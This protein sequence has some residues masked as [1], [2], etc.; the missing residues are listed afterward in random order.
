MAFR[1]QQKGG[2]LSDLFGLTGTASAGDVYRHAIP[3]RLGKIIQNARCHTARRNGIHAQITREQPL[4][5]GQGPQDHRL[6]AE[7]IGADRVDAFGSDEIHQLVRG[8]QQAQPFD[9]CQI[10]APLVAR[11]AGH[12]HDG[13]T[14]VHMPQHRM[15]E[16]PLTQKIDRQN[17]LLQPVAGRQ[18]CVVAQPIQLD[19]HSGGGLLDGGR[20]VQIERNEMI[21]IAAGVL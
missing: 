10:F 7:V 19:R 1:R 5:F 15:G 14:C 11:A 4:G 12:V 3:K 9:L 21:H 16:L 8:P 6:F 18:A 20:V 13:S 2:D 17:C